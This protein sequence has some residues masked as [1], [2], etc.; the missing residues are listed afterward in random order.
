MKI[1]TATPMVTTEAL[2]EVKEFYRGHFGFQVTFEN[3]QLVALRAN[4]QGGPEAM[5]MR[6]G[7]EAPAFEGKGL[8]WCLQ[9]DDV[10]AEHDRAKAAGLAVVRPLQDNPWGDRSFVILDPASI[11]LWIYK[12]IPP[13]AEFKQYFKE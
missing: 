12:P 5:F 1:N 2:T 9:V 7:Q 6:P 13:T 8:S 10:D 11:A 3:D 4:G